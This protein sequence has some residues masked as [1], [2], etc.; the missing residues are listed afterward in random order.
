MRKGKEFSSLLSW[1]DE[2]QPHLGEGISRTTSDKAVLWSVTVQWGKGTPMRTTVLATSSKQAEKFS[3]NRHP[4][5]T[6]ITVI[7]RAK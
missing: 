5:A 2:A 6:T 3:R 7:G 1:A 4:T